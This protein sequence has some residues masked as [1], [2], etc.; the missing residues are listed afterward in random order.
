MKLTQIERQ[1]LYNQYQILSILCPD[2]QDYYEKKMTIL[3]KGYELRY[4]DGVIDVYDEEVSESDCLFVYDVL[5]MYSSLFFSYQKLDDKSGVSEKDVVFGGFDGNNE[6]K[7]YSFVNFL[8]KDDGRWGEFK[9]V[10][11]NSHGQRVNRYREMLSVY[12]GMKKHSDL[13]KDEIISII[14]P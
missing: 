6:T 13:S 5:D 8:L 14:N 1:M 10:Y 3:Q 12:K 9:D 11:T 4:E 2:E 7:L